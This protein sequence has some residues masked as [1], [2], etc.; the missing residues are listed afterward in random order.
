MSRK[1]GD[2]LSM[3]ESSQEE[4]ATASSKTISDTEEKEKEESSRVPTNYWIEKVAQ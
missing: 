2:F 3:V 4:S 1:N